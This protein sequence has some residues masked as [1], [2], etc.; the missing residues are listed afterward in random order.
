MA[1]SYPTLHQVKASHTTTIPTESPAWMPMLIKVPL[2]S[3]RSLC[4]AEHQLQQFTCSNCLQRQCK[5]SLIGETKQVIFFLRRVPQK[6]RTCLGLLS[7]SSL[8]IHSKLYYQPTETNMSREYVWDFQTMPQ[9][10]V[11][12]T[13]LV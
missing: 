6:L 9:S 11:I 10:L 3:G 7:T 13:E 4:G 12:N 5:H 2:S 8:Q 1:K